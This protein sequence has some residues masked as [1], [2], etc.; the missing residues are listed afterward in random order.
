MIALSEPGT[1]VM[2]Q[3]MLRNI[4]NRVEKNRQA[5]S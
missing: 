2:E 4:R 3:K 1:F 5:A